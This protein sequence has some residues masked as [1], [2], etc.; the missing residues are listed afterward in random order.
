MAASKKRV[1]ISDIHMGD[2]RSVKPGG[3]LTPYCWFKNK[4]KRNPN[5]P[6]ML[7]KFLE[8]EVVQDESIDELVILGDLFDEWICPADFSPIEKAGVDQLVSIAEADQNK[9]VVTCLKTL[10]KAGRLVYVTGNHDML[11]TEGDS[12]QVVLDM[13]EGITFL[14]EGGLGVYQTDDGIHALHGHKYTLFNSPWMDLSGKTGLDASILPMGFFISR[15]DAQYTAVKG[16]GYGFWALVRDAILEKLG[17]VK[18]AETVLDA[19]A[20][21]WGS[22]GEDIYNEFD[23]LLIDCFDVFKNDAVFEGQA[24]VTMDELDMVP[25]VATWEEIVNRYPDMMADWDKF[26]PDNVSPPLAL[27]NESG[28]LSSAAKYI[29]K[30]QNRKIVIMGHTHKWKFHQWNLDGAD[31]IYANSGTWINEEPATYVLTE[32]DADN[33]KHD[34]G[35]YKYTDK[36]SEKQNSGS[37]E[38]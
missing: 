37:V 23:K 20:F 13:F 33:G 34:V 24:G 32:Y 12:R 21:D 29:I 16:E 14:G 6:K 9:P 22:I 35:V 3:D 26:H 25:G 28:S 7:A 15:L 38:I 1:F 2:A 17:V 5:R 27:Y 8:T 19:A 36:G 18:A 11:A 10:A 30:S 31:R 4:D